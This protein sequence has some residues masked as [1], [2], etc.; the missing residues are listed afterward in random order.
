MKI[1]RHLPR[2]IEHIKTAFWLTLAYAIVWGAF[3]GVAW[4]VKYFNPGDPI[5]EKIFVVVGYGKY[6]LIAMGYFFAGIA[7][8]FIGPILWLMSLAVQYVLPFFMPWGIYLLPFFAVI[9][10][11]WR[12]IRDAMPKIETTQNFEAYNGPFGGNFTHRKPG[13]K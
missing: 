5:A 1:S 12:L 8:L 3:L 7:Y 6:P 2:V 4:L 11:F 9:Y 13:R 10:F